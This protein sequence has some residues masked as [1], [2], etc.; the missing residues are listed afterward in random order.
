MASIFFFVFFFIKKK[1]TN[2]RIPVF[3]FLLVLRVQSQSTTS[4][5]RGVAEFF[6]SNFDGRVEEDARAEVVDQKKKEK[7]KQKKNV[8]K[9]WPIARRRSAADVAFFDDGIT[10]SID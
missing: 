2:Q 4:L 9:R 5:V 6:L 3:L 10:L 1:Q 7:T 8:D